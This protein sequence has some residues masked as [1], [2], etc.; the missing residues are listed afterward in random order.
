MIPK[1]L[2]TVSVLVAVAIELQR[3]DYS[4]GMTAAEFEALPIVSIYQ[5]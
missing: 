3:L 4:G 2:H 1:S 5:D